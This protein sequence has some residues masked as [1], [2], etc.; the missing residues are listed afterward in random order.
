MHGWL[1]AGSGACR[2]GRVYCSPAPVHWQGRRAR[3]LDEGGQRLAAE[4]LRQAQGARR[5]SRPSARECSETG[6]VTRCDRRI[7]ARFSSRFATECGIRTPRRGSGDCSRS[8]N[9]GGAG[10]ASGSAATGRAAASRCGSTDS[11][12]G[13]GDGPRRGRH[14]RSAPLRNQ[15]RTDLRSRACGRRDPSEG[16]TACAA[17]GPERSSGRQWRRGRRC[18]GG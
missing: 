6:R 7:C 14:R 2:S 9:S 18:G 3:S 1:P 15:L 13:Q 16:L 11:A 4:R 10:N 8:S 5:R 17:E 12:V